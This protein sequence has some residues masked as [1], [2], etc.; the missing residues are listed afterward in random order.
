MICPYCENEMK[1][2]ILK[3]DGRCATKFLEDGKKFT[4]SDL[5]NGTGMIDANYS[6]GT[7]R[8]EA[9]HCKNCKKMIINTDVKQ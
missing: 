3:G 5:I 2:G 1:K 4:F 8:I 6:F 7:F 9:Y